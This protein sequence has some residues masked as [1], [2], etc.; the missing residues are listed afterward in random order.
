V[1]EPRDALSA[2]VEQLRVERSVISPHV[3]GSDEEPTLG[4]LVAAGRRAAAAPGEYALV[5]ESVREG[6]L[7]H[8]GQPRIVTPPDQDLALLTGDYLYAL[9]LE[10]LAALGD[11]EAVRELADLI[12]LE[13]QLHG[14]GSAAAAEPLWA[15]SVVAVACGETDAHR[16]AKEAV[17]LGQADA[18][19]LLAEAAHRGARE[20]G[21][22]S[23]LRH[24]GERINLVAPD[25]RD[26]G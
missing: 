15:S 5:V 24:A 7:L 19:M 13:A 3:R 14:D 2:L 16:R 6:Y 20:G 21:V 23:A 22:E 18:A 1:S 17:R 4:L 8:Y 12:S 26:S 10:R 25:P 9:G 11:L